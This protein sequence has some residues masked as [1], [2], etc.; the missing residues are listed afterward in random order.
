MAM[1]VV[2]VRMAVPVIVGVRVA[3]LVRVAVMV[4]V[5][6]DRPVGHHMLMVVFVIV[7]VIMIVIGARRRVAS[8]NPAHQATSRSCTRMSSPD[9]TSN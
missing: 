2:V 1:V 8:A 3:V 5:A 4:T 9:T 6:H 7:G